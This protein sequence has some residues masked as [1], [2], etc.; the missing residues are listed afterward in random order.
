[1]HIVIAGGSGFV[2]KALQELLLNT[3]YEVTILTRSPNKIKQT[4]RLRAV[5]WLVDQSEPEKQ[6]GKVDAIVNLAGESINGLRWTKSKKE[7]ILKSRIIVTKEINRIIS[8]LEKKPKVLVNASAVGYYGMSEEKTFTEADGSPGTDF[9][10]AVVNKWEKEARKAEQYG[11]RTVVARFGIVL[12]QD[13]ALPLMAFPYKIGV[14]GT[15][16]SGE[17]WVSWVHV[18]DVAGMIQFAIEHQEIS[19]PLNVTAPKPLKMKE[20][21]KTIGIVL[22]RPHWLPVPSWLLK[23]LLG[24]MSE[25]LINGQQVLPKKAHTHGYVFKYPNLNQALN[26]SF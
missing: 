5:Q 17:Q 3:D 11:V 1:M 10:A 23:G 9:L 7:R 18:A 19:G 16:G 6:L 22:H 20:F 14:G 26:D 4:D 12:G 25:M 8:R 24:E 15:I 13:G 2:G 21:G